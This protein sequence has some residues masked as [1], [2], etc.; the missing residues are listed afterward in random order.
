[1]CDILS[2]Y[3][4]A[5]RTPRILPAPLSKQNNKHVTK[6]KIDKDITYMN[7]VG[8]HTFLNE[9]TVD[10]LYKCSYYW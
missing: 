8:Y 9:V 6:L 10:P 7:D 5:S 4:R 3:A 1:M 2:L